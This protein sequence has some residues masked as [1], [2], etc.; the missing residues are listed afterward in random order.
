MTTLTKPVWLLD[1]DGVI[2]A[3]SRELP[4]NNHPEDTWNSVHCA[5]MG[6]IWPITWSTVVRDFLL[7]AHERVEIRWHTTWQHDAQTIADALSLPEWEVQPAP[8][9]Y[10]RHSMYGGWGGSPSS[11]WKMGGALDVVNNEKR[12]LIWTDDDLSN[13][14]VDR[15]LSLKTSD[16]PTI[17]VTPDTTCG[18]TANQLRSISAFIEKHQE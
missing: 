13:F 14:E 6:A 3:C 10:S 16:V 1:V 7:D 12:P 8:E 15:F 17:L 2:N 5:A 9:F 18:L 4:T 11:W